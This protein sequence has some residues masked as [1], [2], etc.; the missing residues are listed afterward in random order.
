[1]MVFF[2]LIIIG[3]IELNFNISERTYA[4]FGWVLRCIYPVM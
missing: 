1:M 3:K 4:D 2:M